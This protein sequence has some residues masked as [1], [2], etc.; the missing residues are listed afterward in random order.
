MMTSRGRRKNEMKLQR[1]RVVTLDGRQLARA[2]RLFMLYQFE[3]TL[4][5][6]IVLDI[7]GPKFDEE[8]DVADMEVKLIGEWEEEDE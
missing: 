4:P 7:Q 5:K 3:I 8:F 1:R 6:N 2:L